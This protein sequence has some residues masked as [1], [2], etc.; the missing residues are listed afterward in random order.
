LDFWLFTCQESGA[1]REQREAFL[2][3]VSRWSKSG[4]EGPRRPADLI[5]VSQEAGLGLG[6]GDAVSRAFVRELGGLN[7]AVAHL[8]DRVL[9]VAAGLPLNLKGPAF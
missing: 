1:F 4:S 8:A 2:E 9:F 7:Q 3:V 5:L 6:P